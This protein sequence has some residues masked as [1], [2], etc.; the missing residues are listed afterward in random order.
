MM[1][2]NC[3]LNNIM[4]QGHTN[5]S[6]HSL[7]SKNI[8]NLI[9]CWIFPCLYSWVDTLH[10][11]GFSLDTWHG[12]A[13]LN[14][15]QTCIS[16]SF[17]SIELLFILQFFSQVITFT[18]EISLSTDSHT[19]LLKDLLVQYTCLY[20]SH[21]NFGFSCMC[22]QL[23][24]FFPFCRLLTLATTRLLCFHFLIWNDWHNVLSVKNT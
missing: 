12:L 21:L 3:L 24:L 8:S 13:Q 4:K 7:A 19:T 5:K 18:R 2:F 9:F 14:I 15:S 20:W 16:T 17:F 10:T 22:L 1:A 23:C 11:W 6:K